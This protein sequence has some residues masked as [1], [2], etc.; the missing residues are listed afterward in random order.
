M[1]QINTD[2]SRDETLSD[3]CYGPN[4]KKP[5]G[6]PLCAE[7]AMGRANVLAIDSVMKTAIFSILI[8]GSTLL[9]AGLEGI[10]VELRT[11]AEKGDAKSQ[12]AL[13]RI[14]DVGRGVK[15][16]YAEAFRWYLKA[17]E[18]EHPLAQHMVG[19]MYR[20]GQGVA[21][22]DAEAAK[23]FRRGAENGESS[24][25]NNLGVIYEYGQGGAQDFSQAVKWYRKSAEQG[26]SGGQSNL[27]AMYKYGKGVPQ[28]F[29]E[30]VKWYQRAASQDYGKAQTNLG[31][32]YATG[33]GVRLSN[34]EAY[35]WFTLAIK[36]GDSNGAKNR[37][38]LV[39]RMRR[40]EIDQG[41]LQARNYVKGKS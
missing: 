5:F 31:V 34:I 35:K 37:D 18:Q 28:D 1:V 19:E 6:Y 14:F 36:N 21:Q 17:A 38:F 3:R 20:L 7:V 29:S 9:V 24:A 41:E 16:D 11:N 33:K 12:F 27:G 32:M 26:N 23:W 2:W 8:F 10:T 13:G 4:G 40:E 30:A 25:Q 15:Q 22:S 39:K